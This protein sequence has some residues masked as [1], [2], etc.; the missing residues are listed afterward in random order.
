MDVLETYL[1]GV[2]LEEIFHFLEE[3]FVFEWYILCVF[4]LNYLIGFL[5]I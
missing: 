1:R 5:F 3:S 2:L 4:S